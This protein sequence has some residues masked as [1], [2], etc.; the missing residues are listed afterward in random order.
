VYVL[1]VEGETVVKGI[2]DLA[3]EM[4][5][6]EVLVMMVDDGGIQVAEGSS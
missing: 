4:H 6:V 1:F 2:G 5:R 3:R